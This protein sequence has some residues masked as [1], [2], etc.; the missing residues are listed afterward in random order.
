MFTF[1]YFLMY[2]EFGLQILYT[3]R[4]GNKVYIYVCV[5]VFENFL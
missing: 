5:C 4:V 3:D 2:D 1:L